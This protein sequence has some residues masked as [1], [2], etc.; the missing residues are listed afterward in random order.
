MRNNIVHPGA[1][2]LT[3]EIREIID[4]ARK[5]ESFGVPIIWENIGDPIAKGE[6]IPDWIKEILKKEIDNN[7]SFGYSHTKG[8]EETREFL[9]GLRSQF[10]GAHITKEDVIFFNGLG[11]AISKIYTYINKNARVIGP[12]PAYSTH[13]SAEAAHS[14]SPHITYKLDPHN[15]W[16]PDFDDLRNKIKEHKDI[17]GILIINPDNPTGVVYDKDIMQKFADIAKEFDLFIIC[18]EI[19]TNIWHNG[20]RPVRLSEVIGDVPG[21]SMRGISKE[22][23]WPGARCGWIEIYNKEKDPQ[24]KKYIQTIINAKML[25]VCSTTLPQKIIPKVIPDPRYK[26]YHKER[27]AIYGKKAQILYD[28]LKDIKGV[29]A[30]KPSGA[31][32]MTVIF[33]DGVLNENQSLEIKN[34]DL[35]KYIEEISKG[36]P[37]DKRFVYYLMASSGI[38]VVPISGFNCDLPGFRITLLEHDI[39]KFKETAETLKEKI[40]NYINSNKELVH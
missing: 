20:V 37:L 17:S 23:P 24:F 29:I 34:N 7:T 4:V 39:E 31:F 32:Y 15:K 9:A 25:E 40:K 26:A 12:S 28:A 3:Y 22:F 14:G 2:E 5:I 33:E 6:I 1:D 35:K 27:N 21:I 11:D 19:Y 18:D 8:V 10:E 36:K 30:N 13:S 38:C 16:F